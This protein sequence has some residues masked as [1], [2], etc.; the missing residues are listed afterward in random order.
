MRKTFANRIYEQLEGDLV[1]TA[2]ALAH[3]SVT[4]TA[5]Y[6]SFREDEI[7]EAILSM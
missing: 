2:R 4:S 5:S 7:D 3:Q 6:L 1:M